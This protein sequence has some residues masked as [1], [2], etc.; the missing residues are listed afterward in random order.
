MNKLI[1]ILFDGLAE[2]KALELESKLIYL[3]GTKYEQGRKGLLVNLE[4]PPRPEF[5]RY[6]HWQKANRNLSAQDDRAV[7]SCQN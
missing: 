4:I 2:A 7:Q 1:H 5:V 6:D 3:M